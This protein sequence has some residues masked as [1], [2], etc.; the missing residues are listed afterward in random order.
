MRIFLTMIAL[1]I[2]GCSSSLHA[3][4]LNR[5]I[6]ST[7]SNPKYIQ[8][9]PVVAP[10][11]EAMGLRPTLALI[12]D[13]DCPIDA[14]L[15]DVIRFTPLPDIPESLQAQVIRLFLPILF[16]DE[17]CL[18]SDIDMLPVSRSYFF[19]G[20]AHC[21][22]DAFLVYRDLAHGW[23]Y[24]RYPM[25]YTAAKGKVFGSVFG[26]SEPKD[27]TGAIPYWAG[28]G[29]GWNTDELL[30]YYFLKEWENTGGHVVRLGHDVGPR[31]D[32]DFWPENINSID[33]SQYIDCHCQRPYSE[34]KEMIDQIVKAIFEQLQRQG[35]H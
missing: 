14:S 6:L 31:I 17:G 3:L 4:E 27:I 25:C 33:V 26:I 11:W 20:A 22:D 32:R 35:S 16:P 30:L 10:L 5:V 18:V 12:A 8:F 28:W 21:P 24:P 13:E 1:L 23:D 34:H 29:Y 7:N 19:D 2:V 15:G 9:W